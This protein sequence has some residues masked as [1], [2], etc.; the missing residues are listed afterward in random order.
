MGEI[1]K[2]LFTMLYLFAAVFLYSG[3]SQSPAGKNSEKKQEQQ[4]KAPAQL[5]SLY[6]TI[7]FHKGKATLTK[8]SK[9]SL[10]E[11]AAKAHH[12]KK[13]I[14]EVRILAWSDK[15]YPDKVKGEASAKEV[16][17]ASERAQKIKDYL[18]E[19][20]KETED[21]DAYNMAKRPNL[22]SKLFQN[23]EYEVKEAFESSGA[24]AAKLPDGSVSYTKASKALVIIDYEGRQDNL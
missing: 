4:A 22:V 6:T 15:E 18:E 2:L 16:K 10:K 23:D 19:D 17:L 13:P 9:E 14:D 20:L 8:E 21:I 12:S 5:G 3:C 24:T 11:L 1:M 7:V